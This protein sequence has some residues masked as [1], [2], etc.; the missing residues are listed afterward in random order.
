MLSNQLQELITDG[1]V[2]RK[3]FGEVPPRTEYSLSKT[4]LSLILVIT[5]M[6]KWAVTH[7]KKAQHGDC[8]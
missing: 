8:L 5:A 4:G 1:I 7:F 2:Q 3:E 6:E